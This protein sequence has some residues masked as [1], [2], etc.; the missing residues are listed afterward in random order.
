MF[1]SLFLNTVTHDSSSHLREESL[2][3]CICLEVFNDP[4][5]TPCGHNFCKNC[6]IKCWDSS[7][8]CCCPLCKEK[9]TNRPA[10]KIN[11]A[12]RGIV[13]HFKETCTLDE[14]EILCDFCTGTT[15]KALKSCLDCG[16]TFCKSH[17]EPHGHITEL[18][19]HKLINPLK[20]LAEYICQKHQKPLK[21]F[22]TDDQICVCEFC[23]EGD[24]RNHTIIHTEDEVQKRK[25]RETDK[26][27]LYI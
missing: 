8:L 6:L 1:L 17:L 10:V 11:T 23:V 16:M 14:A 9:F 18:Q 26:Q 24:H 25:V 3:C 12:L 20:N 4:V 2:L 5:T 19:K 13:E 22:C 7:Q 27:M 15:Q 21:M